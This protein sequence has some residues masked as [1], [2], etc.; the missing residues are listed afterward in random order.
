MNKAYRLAT[1][2]RREWRPITLFVLASIGRSMASIGVIILI[3][4]FF[5]TA[6][7][8]GD[9]TAA[10]FS[11]WIGAPALGVVVALL[12]AVYTGSS[13][14]NYAGQV[15]QYRVTKAVERTLIGQITRH[16]L[17]LSMRF[18]DRQSHGDILQTVRE[19]VTLRSAIVF[20]LGSLFLDGVQA[21]GLVVAAIAIAPRLALW[22][23]L[24]LPPLSLPVILVARRIRARSYAA[25][26]RSHVLYDIILQALIG[27]R[28]IKAYRCEERQ[29]RLGIEAGCAYLEE[30]IA[31]VR[32]QSLA[33]ALLELLAGVGIVVVMVVGGLQVRERVLDWPALLAFVMAI[34]TLQRPLW[35][36]SQQY[37][38]IQSYSA[39]AR[40]IDDLLSTRPDV[41]DRPDAAS[42]TQRP[43]SI[44]F[45]DVNFSY[46]DAPVLRGICF[47]VRSGETIGIVGPSG[48]GK[49]TLLNLIL[50]FYDPSSGRVLF[51]GRDLRQL[52]LAD[53]H[54]Q[55]ALVTQE[56][57]LFGTMIRENIRC[58]RPEA[59]DAEVE[60]AARAACIHETILG[61]P[62][63]YDTPVGLGG[64]AL[65]RGQEQ[66]ITVARAL[67][68]NAPILL[69]DE[70]TASLDSVAEV[71]VQRAI[72]RLMHG[73]TS[74]IV[75]HRL[76]TL[77]NANRLLVLD[78]GACVGLGTNEE[79]LRD[80]PLYRQ[81]WETQRLA[82]TDHC[83]ARFY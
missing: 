3:R 69:L 12:L 23:L 49:T 9:T 70:A 6:A 31:V 19:D 48:A 55:I 22:T 15:T 81:L 44:T 78:R 73:R 46:N 42:L 26:K 72:D 61:L 68:K 40:R 35:S 67:L 54:D 75:T 51:G 28:V 7:G 71:D 65:S 38:T 18:Y 43:G 1:P 33:E 77:R 25:R 58:G 45:E 30:Q 64:R 11:E 8:R 63:G 34:R 4:A 83:M 24:V 59:T 57:F 16:L 21:L 20:S 82:E 14:L 79:L 39:S 60:E 66:R 5:A 27:I 56:P 13:L 53:V 32:M 47:E 2:L 36:M 10:T 52:R 17:S 76:S 50:R 37:T 41:C 80:C 62:L 74:F 29:A